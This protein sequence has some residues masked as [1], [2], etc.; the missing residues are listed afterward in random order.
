VETTTP[1]PLG[2]PF[3]V[4]GAVSQIPAIGTNPNVVRF[5]TGRAETSRNTGTSWVLYAAYLE[6]LTVSGRTYAQAHAAFLDDYP[7]SV[8][9]GDTW[10]A[11]GTL[12]S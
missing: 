12:V 10:T 7:T 4:A 2:Q 3:V 6:D 9:A 8:A 5:G 11:P 1:A